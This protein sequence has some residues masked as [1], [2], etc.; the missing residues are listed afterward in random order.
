MKTENEPRGNLRVIGHVQ[1][2]LV[3]MNIKLDLE[4]CQ[5]YK[6]ANLKFLMQYTTDLWYPYSTSYSIEY[7]ILFIF[8]VIHIDVA[9]IIIYVTWQEKA[10]LSKF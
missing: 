9:I 4:F 10:T 6:D 2:L 7:S 1:I 5:R 8:F 3:E